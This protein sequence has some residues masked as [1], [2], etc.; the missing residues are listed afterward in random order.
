[1]YE[2]SLNAYLK[3]ADVEDAT[4]VD[5]GK[6]RTNDNRLARDA[7]IIMRQKKERGLYHQ[8]S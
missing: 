7:D 3:N 4:H 5:D 8:S 2:I 1:M 6:N